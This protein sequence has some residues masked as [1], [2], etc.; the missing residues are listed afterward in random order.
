MRNRK[1]RCPEIVVGFVRRVAA[2]G[3]ILAPEV[4]HG[5]HEGLRA[6]L[7]PQI[8]FVATLES[9]PTERTNYRMLLWIR[10]K[11]AHTGVASAATFFEQNEFQHPEGQ[12]NY[13]FRSFAGQ[14]SLTAFSSG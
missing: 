9:G 12:P 14:L 6:I 2:S 10:A 4:S 7:L 13:R 3:H 11:V 1:E 5:R 8:E